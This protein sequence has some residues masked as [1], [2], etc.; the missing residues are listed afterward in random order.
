MSGRLARGRLARRSFMVIAA[1]ALAAS[2]VDGK[3]LAESELEKARELYVGRGCVGCHQ[4]PHL[5]QA[6]GL[7]AVSE[8]YAATDDGLQLLKVSLTSGSVGKWGKVEMPPQGHLQEAERDLL[9][10]WVLGLHASG[11]KP[12]GSS[13][14]LEGFA[15]TT[16][17][18]LGQW[19]QYEYFGSRSVT[20]GW[21]KET[22]D[23]SL[24]K[25]GGAAVGGLYR[26]GLGRAPADLVT[27]TVKGVEAAGK[28]WGQV[29]LMISTVPQPQ[30]LDAQARYEWVLRHEDGGAGWVYRV[31]K[32]VG[33]GSYELYSSG[34]VDPAAP[35]K[36]D[37]VRNGDK[38]EFLANGV[39]HYTTGGSYDVKTRDAMAYFGITFGGSAVMSATI[40]DFTLGIPVQG[41]SGSAPPA[42]SGEDLFIEQRNGSIIEILDQP[43][44]YRTYLPDAPSRAIAVGLP[45]EISFGFDAQ[46]CRLLYAWRGGFL[47]VTKSWQSWGGWYSNLLGEKF[48]VAPPGFPL[49]IGD[50]QKEPDLRFKGYDLVDGYPIFK[51][52][53]DGNPVRHRISIS[54]DKKSV[55]H[56]FDLPGNTKPVYFFADEDHR[57]EDADWAEGRWKVQEDKR[58]KFSISTG[59]IQ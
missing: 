58:A 17:F 52:L 9:A 7:D 49:R 50:P 24:R 20:V 19:T 42:P 15:K 30:L 12:P 16:G 2:L 53:V 54:E 1:M 3:P 25:G 23:L 34:P 33:S 21:N 46:N 59:V 37:I 28:P 35:V 4:Y 45:G 43:V 56:H 44:V 27:L 8:K 39:L 51:Y 29:G 13:G 38:Y 57:S 11:E 26:T 6:P 10:R 48:Y 36:L 5:T 18:D 47:D 40:D 22:E 14:T 55:Q 32:D 41:A 31:R